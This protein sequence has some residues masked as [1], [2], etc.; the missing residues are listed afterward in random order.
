MGKFRELKTDQPIGNFKLYRVY[1]C[2]PLGSKV[3][4]EF[5]SA[6]NKA[7]NVSVKEVNVDRAY[8]TERQKK[9]A[10]AN[11]SM[12]NEEVLNFV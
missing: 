8:Y 5:A 1:L 6:M 9:S 12:K 3:T 7:M 10:E 11:A 2:S 4:D